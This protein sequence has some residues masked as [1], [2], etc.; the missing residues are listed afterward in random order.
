MDEVERRILFLL[1]AMATEPLG[2]FEANFISLSESELPPKKSLPIVKPFTASAI[3]DV[4]IVANL[5]DLPEYV[6]KEYN[7]WRA[8]E[9][10]DYFLFA[11]F[12]HQSA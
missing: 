4:R 6:L 5:K 1:T 3:C 12:H 7:S 10:M 9:L 2:A 11:E 8:Q